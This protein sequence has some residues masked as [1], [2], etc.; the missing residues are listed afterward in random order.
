[1]ATYTGTQRG[2]PIHATGDCGNAWLDSNTATPSAALTTSDAVVLLDVPA[3]VYLETLR[4][5]NGDFDTGTT[6]AVNIGYRTKLPG[7]TATALTYFASASTTLQAANAAWQ[8][9]VFAPVKFNEPV[10]IV[11]IPSAN[12]AGVSG[13]PSIF[14]QGM[15][16]VLGVN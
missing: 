6:L 9:L 7:G 14:V 8:E 4:Y 11:L 2:R 5:R 1:M 15:G 10:E 3:G 13:T 16:Q 12:A